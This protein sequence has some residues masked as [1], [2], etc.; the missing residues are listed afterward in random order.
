MNV[1]LNFIKFFRVNR[2]D[3]AEPLQYA[4]LEVVIS[5]TETPE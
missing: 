1:G 4:P 2:A 3:L 5:E